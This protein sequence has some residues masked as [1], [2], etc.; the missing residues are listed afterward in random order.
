MSVATRSALAFLAASA[1]TCPTYA[2]EALALDAAAAEGNGD[3]GFAVDGRVGYRTGIPRDLPVVGALY[4]WVFQ[5]EI[6]GGYRQLFVDTG[7]LHLG[8]VGGGLRVGG[9]FD[10]F[11]PFVYSHCSAADA[12]GNWGVLVDVGGALDWRLKTW[13]LGVHYAHDFLHLDTGWV[14]LNEIG[15]HVEIRGFWL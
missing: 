15:A 6:I 9:S 7:D 3:W 10:W 11:Q 1:V 12:D 4:G 5:L 13:S 8:R 14:D 2:Q